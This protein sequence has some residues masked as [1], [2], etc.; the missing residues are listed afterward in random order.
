MP[1]WKVAVYLGFETGPRFHRYEAFQARHASASDAI[2][3]KCKVLIN[4]F[5]E[6]KNKAK[7]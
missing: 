3:C 6:D 4:N 1:S 7:M 2:Y 5:L